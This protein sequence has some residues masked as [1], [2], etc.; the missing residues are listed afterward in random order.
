MELYRNNK[1]A[2]LLVYDG[3]P[4]T[5]QEFGYELARTMNRKI[6]FS[7][8]E[9]P[10]S[11]RSVPNKGFFTTAKYFFMDVRRRITTTW[12]VAEQPCDCSDDCR[13]VRYATVPKSGWHWAVLRFS[14]AMPRRAKRWREEHLRKQYWANNPRHPTNSFVMPEGPSI[15]AWIYKVPDEKIKKRLKGMA[16]DVVIAIGQ[17]RL[18]YSTNMGS[19]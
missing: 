12:Y 13:E 7:S 4:K 3:A 14:L 9:A 15:P 19:S 16:T 8:I 5:R 11:Q 17:Y 1:G 2:C 10:T 18:E 6:D